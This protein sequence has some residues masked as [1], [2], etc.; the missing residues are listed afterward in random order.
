M[1]DKIVFH[2]NIGVPSDE[3]KEHSYQSA[4]LCYLFLR[5]SGKKKPSLQEALELLESLP[6][7]SSDSST[8]NSSNE[9]VPANNLLE[10]SSES[11]EDDG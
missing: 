7:E 11:E 6:S 4:S 3:Q 5:M 1:V 10:F 8:V 9:E 2:N